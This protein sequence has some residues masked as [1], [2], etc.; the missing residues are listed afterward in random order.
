MRIISRKKIKEFYEQPGFSDAKGPLESWLHETKNAE[1]RSPADIKRRYPSA[2]L[3]KDN[4][5]IFNIGGNK[6][7]LVARINY[8]YKIVYIRFIGTHKEYDR[9]NAEDI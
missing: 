2:S 7:R 5:V 9:I 4:R 1:W 3:I 8:P 6:Y